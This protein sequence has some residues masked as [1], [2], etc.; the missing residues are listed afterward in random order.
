MLSESTLVVSVKGLFY[1]YEF[2]FLGKSSL[3]KLLKTFAVYTSVQLVIECF[4]TSVSLA[5]ETRYQNM[6]D[7]GCLATKMEKTYLGSKSDKTNFLGHSFTFLERPQL[8]G[9][10]KCK[11]Q[12]SQ[13]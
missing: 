11:F 4:F 12:S 1:L 2:V 8:P 9:S 5:I 3:V 13:I 6:A 7:D 10:S